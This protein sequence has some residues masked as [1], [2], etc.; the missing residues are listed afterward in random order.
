MNIFRS[1]S[2]VLLA[3]AAALSLIATPVLARDWHRHRD[4]GIDGGDVLAGLL[5]V[6]GIAAIAT[7]ASNKSKKD[8]EAREDARY[9]DD[10]YRADGERY[11]Y[12]S[13]DYPQNPNGTPRADYGDAPSASA[14]SDYGVD[15]IVDTC[16][17]EVER[18][19]RSV[20][21]IDGVNRE[22]EGWRV[23]GRVSGGY[24]FSCLVDRDG[25]VREVEGLAER[26][27]TNPCAARAEP[28]EG[29]RATVGNGA[30][31][32]RRERV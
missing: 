15:Q 12:R 31:K 19:N 6:G 18:G 23:G 13:G 1:R 11:D 20:Q 27:S 4:R 7:A 29:R 17:G 28:V 16:V 32:D 3:S 24:G 10:D 30:S 2:T 21:T 8:R 5:I 25:R 22:G 26:S 14:R 9:R